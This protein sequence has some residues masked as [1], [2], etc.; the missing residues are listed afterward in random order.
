MFARL[1]ESWRRFRAAPHGTR[2]QELYREH[3][4]REKSAWRRPLTVM[5]GL[6]IIAVGIVALPF[7]GPGTLIIVLGVGILG[8]ESAQLSRF[9]DRAE[10][11]LVPR[12]ARLRTRWGRFR[13]S[14]GSK[15]SE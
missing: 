4:A 13:G 8:R 11:W 3:Q 14:L 1:R 9:L 6:V 5:I 10:C 7:P 15:R 12:V 2:F